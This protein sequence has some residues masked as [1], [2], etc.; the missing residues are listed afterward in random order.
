M[1][2]QS[3][4]RSAFFNPRVLIGFA[5]C[6]IGVLLALVGLSKSVAGTPAAPSAAKPVPLINQPLV[7]DAVAPGGAGF[8][9]T[10]NG[11]GFIPRSVVN[12]NGSPRTSHSDWHP[13][14]LQAL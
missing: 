5:L 6:L 1:E 4:S 3:A 10:V 7:P 2:K 12:W 11:T 8:T 13:W 9:L 14:R